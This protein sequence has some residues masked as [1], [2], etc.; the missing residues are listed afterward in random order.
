MHSMLLNCR[1]TLMISY[2]HIFTAGNNIFFHSVLMHAKGPH[3]FLFC[4]S[5]LHM[6]LLIG[7][8][9]C[10]WPGEVPQGKPAEEKK[11]EEKKE[12]GKKEER[13][14]EKKE[15]RKEDKKEEKKED[16]KEEKKEDKKEEKI[17]QGALAASAA[18]S[19]SPAEVEVKLDDNWL[20]EEDD[21]ETARILE[22]RAAKARAAKAERE[23][24]SS[25]PKEVA[26]STMA[27]EIKPADEDTGLLLCFLLL[28]LFLPLLVLTG[29]MCVYVC[30]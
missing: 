5:A 21:P 20:D 10:S 27:W 22:E 8:C 29:R 26:K 17:K 13:K 3:P 15:E 19:A 25:K 7:L 2:I 12:E 18:S 11:Q 4:Y 1:L 28:F 24:K 6:S 30:L 14:E 9:V 23:A 16:K